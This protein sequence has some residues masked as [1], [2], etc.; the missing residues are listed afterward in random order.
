MKS[1]FAMRAAAGLLTLALAAGALPPFS[2]ADK[3]PLVPA[4]TA[5]AADFTVEVDSDTIILGGDLRN[6]SAVAETMD[7]VDWTQIT[8]LK[9]EPG[10]ILP[11]DASGFLAGKAALEFVD[12]S[13]ADVSGV[14]QLSAFLLG[15]NALREVNLSGL[16]F[17]S[18]RDFSQVFVGCGKLETVDFTG[19]SF[20]KLEKMNSLFVSCN[21][22]KTVKGLAVRSEYLT[23]VAQMFS[24]CASLSEIDL[25]Q[26]RTDSVMDFRS[27]FQNC[28]SL[29]ELDLSTFRTGNATDMAS[30]FLSCR[31]L[32]TLDLGSF[33]TS[34]VTD[35]SYMFMNCTSLRLLHISGF[36]TENIENMSYMFSGCCKLTLADCSGFTFEKSFSARNLFEGC[37]N[38]TELDLSGFDSSKILKADNMFAGMTHLKKLT[39]GALFTGVTESMK[40]PLPVY[41]W[42]NAAD[43]DTV[44]SETA[45][46]GSASYTVFPNTGLNTYCSRG[47]YGEITGTRLLLTVDGSIGLRFYGQLSDYMSAEDLA[48]GDV[49][50]FFYDDTAG[51]NKQVRAQKDGSGNYYA[52]FTVP[53]KNMTDSIQAQ[54]WF[55]SKKVRDL[56]E[57]EVAPTDYWTANVDSVTYSV[58]EYA[59]VILSEPERFEKEQ[60][61]LKAMLCYGGAAQRQ[62]GYY[63]SELRKPYADR[64]ITY[65]GPALNTLD[66]FVKPSDISGLSYYG[67][68][69]V[70]DALTVQRHYFRLTAGSVSDYE[71]TVDGTPVTPEAYTGTDLYYID[72]PGVSAMHLYDVLTV[73]AVSRSDTSKRITYRYS[74]LDYIRIGLEKKQLTGTAADAARALGWLALE[75]LNYQNA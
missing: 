60:N 39:L 49:W 34:N 46:S 30:M 64:G 28:S 75:A 71:F 15:C 31:S 56:D 21:A 44:V 3:N 41:G 50:F 12:L 18:L 4:L 26:L 68:S 52:S 2:A 10:T 69:V 66:E 36:R 1:K 72:T 47:G 54:L 65:I 48:Q 25:S 8:K 61:V 51:M 22:L 7:M 13:G 9:V 70:L 42:V 17:S 38:L 57:G 58:R 6:R 16:S 40:L 19:S 67:T 45:G 43:P 55:Y 24:G 11:T 14:E 20:T 37:E 73:S 33:D 59:D 29:T 74:A 35:M 23:S 53:A 5:A 32:R 63:D 27:M 62:F